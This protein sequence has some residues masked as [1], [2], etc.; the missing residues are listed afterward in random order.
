M[1]A[2]SRLL[3]GTPGTLVPI[4][5]AVIIA[6]L[7]GY[8]S[9]ALSARVTRAGGENQAGMLV[10]SRETPATVRN[11]QRR[12]LEAEILTISP[13]GFQPVE[14]ARR[15]GKFFLVVDDT[16]GLPE[17]S[18]RLDREHGERV[19]AVRIRRED[20]TLSHQ[21]DLNPGRYVLTE[22][23]HPDWICRI[24]ITR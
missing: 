12:R 6:V 9:L 18:L 5:A 21:L 3:Q 17:L 19:H 14:I 4:C 11:S 13:S 22:T 7:I 10:T 1:R 23:N 24:T 2:Q 8:A 20:R 16:S 15:E